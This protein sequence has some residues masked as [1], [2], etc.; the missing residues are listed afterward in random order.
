MAVIVHFQVKFNAQRQQ[1]NFLNVWFLSPHPLGEVVAS[2]VAHSAL[3]WVIWVWC[4]IIVSIYAFPL[5]ESR[6]WIKEARSYAI[7]DE[8]SVSP[9][10]WRCHTQ[11]YILASQSLAW[12][13]SDRWSV[14][15]IS[16]RE[17]TVLWVYQRRHSRLLRGE[18]HYNYSTTRCVW[19]LQT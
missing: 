9:Q 14:T 12:G 4:Q 11:S 16:D 3:L 2:W 7:T 17:S 5:V 18:T 10:H 13:D 6:R 19:Q 15:F 8:K 1:W